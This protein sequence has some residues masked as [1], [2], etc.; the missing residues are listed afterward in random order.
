M[1]LLL[2]ML[3]TISLD[4]TLGT[5]TTSDSDNIDLLVLLEHLINVDGLLQ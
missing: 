4:N 1:G 5:L 2:E 3:D